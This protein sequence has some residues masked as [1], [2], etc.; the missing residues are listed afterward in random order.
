MGELLTRAITFASKKHESQ[1]RKIDKTPAIL[2]SLE[3]ASIVASIVNDEEL[4]VC[5][6][7]HDTV[8]DTDTTIE[9]IREMFGERVASHVAA[10]SENKRPH[11]PASATWKIRKEESLSVLK[12]SDRDSKILWLADKLSNMRTL[13]RSYVLIGD[14]VFNFFNQKD[15]S[16]HAWY[17]HT[18]LDY[19]SPL[20]E[21]TAYQEYAD[22]VQKIFD[23]KE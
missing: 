5:A 14:E 11:L 8:E 9:E 3:A 2:H 4:I 20:S 1:V 12:D 7:L 23:E 6:V 17:Y 16:Q 10:E 15:K 13:Y 21:T 22:L 18:I 19:L